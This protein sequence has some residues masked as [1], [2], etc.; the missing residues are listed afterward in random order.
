MGETTA[1]PSSQMQPHILLLDCDSLF[2]SFWSCCTLDVVDRGHKRHPA[3]YW[4]KYLLWLFMG[5][6][7]SLENFSS[8]VSLARKKTVISMT[9]FNKNIVLSPHFWT[10]FFIL[11]WILWTILG[12]CFTFYVKPIRE[13]LIE[14]KFLLTRINSLECFHSKSSTKWVSLFINPQISISLV[15]GGKCNP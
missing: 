15:V 7:I 10:K 11:S 12:F 4:P 13:M 1:F 5:G 2:R 3:E 8:K 9:H 6:P 14:E